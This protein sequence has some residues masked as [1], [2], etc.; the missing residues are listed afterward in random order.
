MNKLIK[1]CRE[2]TSLSE[3]DIERLVAEIKS[4][5]N[6]RDFEDFD[7]FIDVLN[8]FN[9]NALVVYHKLPKN[10]PSLYHEV[11]VG[12][13]ALREN[14][15]GVF[16]TF[17]TKLKSVNLLAKTQEQKLIHQKIFPILNGD[18]VIGTTIVE[19]DVSHDVLNDFEG[20]NGKTRYNDISAAIQMF[21]RLDRNVA[22]QLG[23][24]ILGFDQNGKLVLANQTALALY[25]KVG[26]IGNVIGQT[27]ENLSL[28]GTTF[29]HVYQQLRQ[30]PETSQPM[31]TN[32]NY[33]NYFFLSRKFWNEKSKQLVILIQ[34]RTEVKIKEAEIVSKSVMLREINHRVKNNLQSVI[35]LL[36]IQQRRLKSAEAKKVLNESVSRIMAIASTY[37]LM[38]K[39]LGDA[40]NLKESIQLLISHFVQ[41]NDRADQLN[42]ELDV[43]PS[44]Q[45]DSDQVVTVSIIINEL[46]QNVVSHA[47]SAKTISTGR[48]LIE[49]READEIITIRVKDNGTGFDLN[50]TRTGSLGLT[51]I[52][53]YVSDKL[54]GRLKIESSQKGTDVSFSFDQKTQ[55]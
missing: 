20:E 7:V 5:E 4:I 33:L 45:I 16:H 34:D 47:F 41:L 54:L 38:S 8:D 2:Y 44:I 1:L 17:G 31:I 27:Y 52:R 55:H 24:A 48:V 14:E 37:E 51:I 15:P 9:T 3:E 43:D 25:K 40:T 12:K 36:R 23:D 6:N 10:V 22:D 49:S 32:F 29:D 39:Q 11:V 53:S 46:L 21:G 30:M 18:K 28:D 35:S 42:I 13:D 26:Y 50:H 19:S